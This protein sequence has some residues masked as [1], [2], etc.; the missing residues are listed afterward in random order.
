MATL[1]Y[2]L[3]QGSHRFSKYQLPGFLKV[4]GPKF[5]G[6]SR[7]FCAKFQVFFHNDRAK[8]NICFCF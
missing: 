2:N 6:F 3:Y 7:F 1:A 5:Q 4:F 8:P